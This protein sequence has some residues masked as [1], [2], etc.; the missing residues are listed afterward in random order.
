[1]AKH[2]PPK[3]AAKIGFGCHHCTE[4]RPP[5]AR[6]RVGLQLM[7]LCRGCVAAWFG[8]QSGRWKKA[9]GPKAPWTDSYQLRLD[10]TA[11]QLKFS[12]F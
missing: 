6:I 11:E 8:D 2:I 5:F 12:G 7:K 9:L 1:M 10:P 3:P 4:G